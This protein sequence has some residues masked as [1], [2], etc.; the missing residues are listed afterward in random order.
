MLP[1]VGDYLDEVTFVELQREE[2]YELVKRYNEEGRKAGPPPEKRFDNGGHRRRESGF[3]RYDNHR[4]SRGGHQNR[5]GPGGSYRGG[6]L[7]LLG[8]QL[9]Q[10]SV[11]SVFGGIIL[12]SAF[13][14]L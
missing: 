7:T 8:C 11:S 14:R 4:G 10:K 2:A 1:E 5:G 3:Q 9:I 13:V 12:L 6:E